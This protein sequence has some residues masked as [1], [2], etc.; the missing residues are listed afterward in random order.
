MGYKIARLISLYLRFRKPTLEGDRNTIENPISVIIRKKGLVNLSNGYS[1]PFDIDTKR[2]VLGMVLFALENGIRFG[3]GEYQWKLDYQ[4]GIVETHQGIKFK[5]NK[6]R[7]LDETF[8]SQI[9]FSGLDLGNKV[10]VTAGAYI[11]D[12]PLFFSYYGARVYGFEPDPISYAQALDNIKLN[13]KLSEDIVLRNYAIGIDGTIDFPMNP[14]DSG[15]SSIYKN[16]EF[17]TVKIES[18]SISTIINEFSIADP[19]LLDLDIK[20]SEFSVIE[21]VSIKKFQKIRIEYTP[22]LLNSENKNLDYLINKL[23]S[24][25]FSKFRI[26][27]HNNL[28]FDLM[29][30]GTLEA[31][32]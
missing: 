11:G 2:S 6:A 13:P 24:Y 15:G 14:N 27:K 8:L 26:Y 28:R 3:H 25:G 29:N 5:I 9:H 7:L 10:V 31:E 4:N 1:I 32:K 21:D 17:K 20:G 22:Y 23:K 16:G 19:Y 12:T 30:H 18:K